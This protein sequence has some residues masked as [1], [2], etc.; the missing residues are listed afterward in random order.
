MESNTYL[1]LGVGDIGGTQLRALQISLVKL[2]ATP[3]TD[4]LICTG[5]I[6]E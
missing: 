1:N 5:G 6:P 2:F 3:V 4:G